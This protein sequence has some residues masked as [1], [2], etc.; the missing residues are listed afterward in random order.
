MADF[1]NAIGKAR[2][3]ETYCK[4]SLAETL[5][6]K[7]SDNAPTH[8]IGHARVDNE[9]DL[10]MKAGCAAR[11]LEELLN[12]DLPKVCVSKANGDPLPKQLALIADEAT[13]QLKVYRAGVAEALLKTEP[14]IAEMKKKYE[15][16][17][18]ADPKHTAAEGQ[19]S[20]EEL[21][22]LFAA[23]CPIGKKLSDVETI[24]GSPTVKYEGQL[25]YSFRCNSING[26][27]VKFM[28]RKDVIVAVRWVIGKD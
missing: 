4:I 11:A 23:W 14:S 27:G 6:E 25:C 13:R 8:L 1:E 12:F 16:K 17:I 26:A 20:I 2:N 28:I 3:Y 19:R 18:T 7:L 24:V 9:Q 15:N 10:D 21:A 22:A 5:I